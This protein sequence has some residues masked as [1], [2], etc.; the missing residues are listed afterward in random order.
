MNNKGES[1]S[2]S[3]LIFIMLAIFLIGGLFYYV[4]GYQD[5]AALWED[6]YSKEIARV[7]NSAEPGS[8]VCLDVTKVVGI[9]ENRG[10]LISNAFNFNN[11]DN[12]IIVSLRPNGGTSFYFFNNVDLINKEVKKISGGFDRSRLCF[13]VVSKQII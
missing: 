5:G 9:A 6:F 12:E 13:D 8:S 4:S 2:A 10:Q 1:F 11:V 7:V 3:Q